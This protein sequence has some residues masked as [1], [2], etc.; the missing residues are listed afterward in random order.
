M[1]WSLKPV[2]ARSPF[3]LA[4]QKQGFLENLMTASKQFVLKVVLVHAQVH[5][6]A[7]LV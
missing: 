3:L 5:Y 2:A 4:R 1:F 7:P 6:H